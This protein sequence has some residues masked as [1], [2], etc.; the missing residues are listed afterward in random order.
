MILISKSQLNQEYK[1]VQFNLKTFKKK[2]FIENSLSLLTS[3][4]IHVYLFKLRAKEFH[5]ELQ[6]LTEGRSL[7]SMMKSLIVISFMAF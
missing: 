5:Q 3:Q 1:L 4:V 2:A 6:S 7:L